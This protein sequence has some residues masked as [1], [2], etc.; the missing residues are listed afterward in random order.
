MANTTYKSSIKPQFSGVQA[1][2]VSYDL[3]QPKQMLG[4][5]A[6]GV[7]Q[8]AKTLQNIAQDE[9]Q[10]NFNRGAAEL[11]EKYGTDY[12][13]LNDA[14]LKLE[15]GSYDDFRKHNPELAEDLLRQQ[16]AVRLRAVATARNKYVSNNNKKIKETSGMLLEGYKVAMPDDY[17]NYLD[18][19]R[20]PAEQQDADLIGQWENNLQQI[21]TLLNRKDMDGNYIF[22]EKSRKQRQFIQG[23]MT[24]GAKKFIDRLFVD[25][26]EEG[27]KS[28]Y[29]SQIL[30][31]ERYMADTGMDR[32]TYD[33][34]RDYAKKTLE[35]MGTDTKNMKFNQSVADAISLQYEFSDENLAEL[36]ESGILP[37]KITKSL[38][39]TNVK[40]S[41]IDPSKAELPTALI[42]T[43]NIVN[44]FN[45]DYADDQD[46]KLKTIDEGL[47]AMNE[48]ADYAQKNGLSQ[49]NIKR[50]QEMI[51]RKEQ[52]ALFGDIYKHF[53]NIIE[54]FESKRGKVRRGS[55]SFGAI[56]NWD[57]MP[58]YERNQIT[59]LEMILGS[60]IDQIHYASANGEPIAPILE[61]T[62]ENAAKLYYQ[63]DISLAD[64][65]KVDSDPDSV[66]MFRGDPVKVK[67]FT[68]DGDIIFERQ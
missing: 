15:Q 44:K 67:G 41:K 29:Q 40:F 11:V 45:L 17:A 26:D 25:N 33:K 46:A 59:Q 65:A 58:N 39:D 36:E 18:T 13:G 4:E 42:D 66:I 43:L 3:S 1:Q 54:N 50:A 31:P 20:K 24:D 64:W 48:L 60:A 8:E 35:Q 27:L 37:K 7:E 56:T 61:K 23:Y 21:D 57:G 55:T 53:G 38:K 68:D 12:K 34:V 9:S 32:D 19:I 22:D 16:D 52:D 62:Y 14:L 51:V 28:Y 47:S 63:N 2:D 10:I 30:A 49:S 5:I 6:K